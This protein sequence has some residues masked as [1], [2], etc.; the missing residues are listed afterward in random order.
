MALEKRGGM[1]RLRED[2]FEKPVVGVHGGFVAVF[3]VVHGLKAMGAV[4][5]RQACLECGPM[6]SN[7]QRMKRKTTG[8]G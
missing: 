2:G 4:A 1:L 7:A 6:M 3:G 8:D 5:G